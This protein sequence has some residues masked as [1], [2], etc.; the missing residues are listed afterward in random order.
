[1]VHFYWSIDDLVI[2]ALEAVHFSHEVTQTIFQ[3]ED[4][5]VKD[6]KIVSPYVGG[7]LTLCGQVGVVTI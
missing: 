1:M 3:Y 6:W 4:I 2:V 5:I 7:R